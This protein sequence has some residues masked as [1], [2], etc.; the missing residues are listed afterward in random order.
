MES[1]AM[2]YMLAAVPAA[3]ARAAA[4]GMGGSGGGFV[5][6]PKTSSVQLTLRDRIRGGVRRGDRVGGRLDR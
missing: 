2:L 4:A 1:G 6:M 5:R 3:Q